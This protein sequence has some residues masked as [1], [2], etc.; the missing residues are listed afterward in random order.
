MLDQLETQQEFDAP[1]TTDN[2]ISSQAQDADQIKAALG[3]MEQVAAGDFEARLL[4]ITAEGDLGELLHTI[5]D[6]VDRCDSYVRE[7][8][9]CMDHVNKNQYFRTIIETGMQGSFL[10]AGKTVNSALG[11][12]QEKVDSFTKIAD[13]FETDVSSIVQGVSHAATELQ[14]SAEAMTDTA[15]SASEQSTAVAAAAEE[16]SV[17]VQTVSASSEQLMS[18]IS[19]ISKQIA[20]STSVAVEASESSEAVAGQVNELQGAVDQIQNAVKIIKEIAD[21]TNLLALNATIEAARAGEAGKGFAVVASEVKALAAQTAKATEDVGG[22]VKNILGAVK[23]TVD[24]VTEISGR[25]DEI[26]HAS[27]AVSAAVEEQTAATQEIARNIEQASQG[28]SEVTENINRVSQGVAETESAA[29]EVKSAASELS[30]Q[31]ETLKSAVDGFLAEV[32]K[33]V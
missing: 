2:Q 15:A 32:R 31:S 25:I 23:M 14:A 5:N 27:A 30:E 22:Y 21:Q 18:S 24:G 11:A 1:E 19:E 26:S 10:N 29:G 13:V 28:T 3:V 12:M 16:A 4:N 17:N 20:G 6:L 33:A 7:S 9:A 8:A